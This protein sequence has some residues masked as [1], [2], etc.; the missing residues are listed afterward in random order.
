M[1]THQYSLTYTVR[2][3][4]GGYSQEDVDEKV[5]R[6]EI[7][8]ACDSLL[9]VSIKYDN[10]F[11]EANIDMFDQSGGSIPSIDMFAVWLGIAHKLKDLLPPGDERDLVTDVVDLTGGTVTDPDKPPPKESLS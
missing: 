10:G 11:A 3:R 5:K 9:L 2:R 8:G 4:E 6:G 7:N 1:S